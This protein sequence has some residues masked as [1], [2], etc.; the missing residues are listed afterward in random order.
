MEMNISLPRY[1]ENWRK[2]FPWFGNPVEV[3]SD[4]G[5]QF[6]YKAFEDFSKESWGF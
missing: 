6:K 2:S 3:V 1:K 4:G 5:P